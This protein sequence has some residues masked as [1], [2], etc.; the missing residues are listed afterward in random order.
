[1]SASTRVSPATESSKAITRTVVYVVL[2]VV[3][4]AIVQYVFASLLPSFKVEIAEYSVY[5]QILIAIA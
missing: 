2:Y 3:V 4:S 1:M 5:A